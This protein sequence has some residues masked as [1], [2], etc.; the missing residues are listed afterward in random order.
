MMDPCLDNQ[1]SPMKQGA[2]CF[3]GIEHFDVKAN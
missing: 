1:T 2:S 3:Q